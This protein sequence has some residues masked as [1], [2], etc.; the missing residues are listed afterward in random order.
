MSDQDI[1]G[2]ADLESTSGDLITRTPQQTPTGHVV[3][4][5]TPELNL[6][7][8]DKDQN[9]PYKFVHTDGHETYIAVEQDSIIQISLDPY[10]QW[11]FDKD[12]GLLSFKSGLHRKYYKIQY[13]PTQDPLLNLL[14]HAKATGKPNTDPQ[15]HLFDLHL[16][17]NQKSIDGRPGRPLP[18]TIDPIVKN[19]PPDGSSP[20]IDPVPV[21]SALV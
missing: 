13:R 9:A 17:I 14:L 4:S 5:M 21:L 7:M 18:M 8:A 1:I 11:Q 15:T 2:A 10:F 3:I 20:A 16:I 6:T 12:K 19:P